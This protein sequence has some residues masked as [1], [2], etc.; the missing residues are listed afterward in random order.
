MR[1][2]HYHLKQMNQTINR[3]IQNLKITTI[4]LENMEMES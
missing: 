3:D 1:I 2:T 4:F